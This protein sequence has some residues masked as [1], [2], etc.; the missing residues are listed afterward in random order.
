MADRDHF[1]SSS[2]SDPETTEWNWVVVARGTEELFRATKGLINASGGSIEYQKL[3]RY[4]FRVEE[5]RPDSGDEAS[6]QKDG[7]KE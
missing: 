2:E 1:E 4:G 7:A 5:M 6:G 3:G